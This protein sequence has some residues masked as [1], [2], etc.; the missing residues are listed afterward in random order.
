MVS[1]PGVPAI[2]P[3]SGPCSGTSFPPRGP[4][5]PVPPLPG[6][7]ELL[8]LPRFVA[9]AWR[10]LTCVACSLP[11]ASGAPPTGLGF[12]LRSPDRSLARRRPGLPGPWGTLCVHALLSDPGEIS[13]PGL[14]GTSMQPSALSTPSALATSDLTGFH[15][16]ACTLPVYA[17][18]PGSLPHH[19]TL[20]SGGWPTFAGRDWLPAGFPRRFQPSRTVHGVLLLQV[21]LAH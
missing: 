4:V 16:T 19:A 9:F 5:G 12:G 1:R 2:V 14:Y 20:G 21:F 15:P 11:P 13:V 17:S 18:Q 3:S 8:R 6:Y 7:Y 10:Y